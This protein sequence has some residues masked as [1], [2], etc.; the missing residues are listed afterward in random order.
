MCGNEKGMECD[1]RQCPAGL[2][3]SCGNGQCA[4]S[5]LM[6]KKLPTVSREET[7]RCSTLRD[8]A[9]QCELHEP[10]RL[11]TLANG[12]CMFIDGA[13]GKIGTT[14]ESK[15]E[16]YLKCQFSRG[17]SDNCPASSTLSM[18][19]KSQCK[20]TLDWIQYP[21]G[22]L[23]GPR[24][25]TFYKADHQLKDGLSPDYVLI[26][27]QLRCAGFH[28]TANQYEFSRSIFDIVDIA[29]P[30]TIEQFLCQTRENSVN[31]SQL[32]RNYSVFAPH[33]DLSCWSQWLPL[34]NRSSITE[35]ASSCTP[36]C[37]SSHRIN[38][39]NIDCPL[40]S[41]DQ[42]GIFSSLQPPRKHCLNCITNERQAICLPT[43]YVD[44]AL[45]RCAQGEDVYIAGIDR[46]INDFKC[47]QHDPSGCQI[48]RD[49]II[50]SS[51]RKENLTV[52]ISSGNSFQVLPFQQH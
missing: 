32:M 20:S 22:S 14:V 11:W 39:G 17:L 4:M 41:I 46:E 29:A 43:E 18:L 19:L 49:H 31:E 40:S 7:Y 8:I 24:T 16:F 38:D 21:S 44:S 34:L 1:E 52:T 3:M 10:M 27:G 36:S 15:C 25:Y 23:F 13:W 6:R 33:F 2:G 35:I 28:L 48:I 47:T 5:Y 9:F 45:S 30:Y 50:A 37:L 26:N 12:F 51:S 42:M